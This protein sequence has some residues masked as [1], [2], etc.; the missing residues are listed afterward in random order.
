MLLSN[1][2]LNMGFAYS[3]LQRLIHLM[4]ESLSSLLDSLRSADN[5]SRPL[6]DL[7]P[8]L[9]KTRKL[10]GMSFLSLFLSVELKLAIGSVKFSFHGF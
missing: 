9:R 8:S 5:T 2:L 1:W 3:Q 7:I 10:A 4:L 6:D